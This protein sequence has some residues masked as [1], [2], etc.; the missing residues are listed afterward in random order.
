MRKYNN[1]LD[2]TFDLRT[3]YNN[4][5]LERQV[6]YQGCDRG[7]KEYRKYRGFLPEKNPNPKIPY[8]PISGLQFFH[9][10]GRFFAKR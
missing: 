3:N 9:N 7:C 6:V 5:M 1:I 4:V 2:P 10:R 8:F